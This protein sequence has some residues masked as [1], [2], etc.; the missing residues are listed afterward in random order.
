[1]ATSLDSKQSLKSAELDAD[2]LR[3]DRRRKATS[4]SSSGHVYKKDSHLHPLI[5]AARGLPVKSQP[6]NDEKV[7]KRNDRSQSAA[8]SAVSNNLDLSD[9]GV[10]AALSTLLAPYQNQAPDSQSLSK[11][12][13]PRSSKVINALLQLMNKPPQQPTDTSS[14]FAPTPESSQASTTAESAD[15]DDEIVVLEKENVDPGTFRR[16]SGLRATTGGTT[17]DSTPKRKRTLSD[18]AEAHGRPK[19][20]C[21]SSPP[22][23]K[24]TFLSR[25]LL[26]DPVNYP[27]KPVP[28]QTPRQN[29]DLFAARSALVAAAFPSPPK[30]AHAI[31]AKPISKAAASVLTPNPAPAPAVVKKP[32]VVPEWARTTTATKPRISVE[33]LARK[34]AE[35]AREHAKALERKRANRRRSRGQAAVEQPPPPPPTQSVSVRPSSAGIRPRRSSLGESN[36][37]ASMSSVAPI[38]AAATDIFRTSSPPPSSPVASS[39]PGATVSVSIA[40]PCT[41]RRRPSA[42]SL[43]HAD[44]ATSSSLTKI[45]ASNSPLFSPEADDDENTV[46]LAKPALMLSPIQSVLTGRGIRMGIPASPLRCMSGVVGSSMDSCEPAN[47][48][49]RE[50]GDALAETRAGSLPTPSDDDEDEKGR[51]GECRGPVL[52]ASK[53]TRTTKR[54]SHNDYG[55][56]PF[57]HRRHSR[58]RVLC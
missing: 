15:S 51:E 12:T 50:N 25:P 40:V 54:Q 5:K 17:S 33:A 37:G 56:T 14:D 46:M 3:R 34:E 18:V 45:A 16:R 44:P 58:R 29:A 21:D 43:R 39:S 47:M 19:R 31:P 10:R 13:S 28:V 36:V 35:N 55:P 38:T 23:R 1:M 7:I 48:S 22:Q 26:S 49:T 8:P 57:H 42:T 27:S 4:R 2:S 53:A 32:Y 24:L 20:H 9:S 6:Q 52:L 30:T 11:H 41:P